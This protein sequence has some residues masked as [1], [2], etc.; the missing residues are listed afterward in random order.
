[1]T[2]TI[3]LLVLLGAAAVGR[4]APDDKPDLPRGPLDKFKALELAKGDDEERK[5]LKER[6]NV[7]VEVLKIELVLFQSGIRDWTEVAQATQRLYEAQIE[8]C[9]TPAERVAVREQQL[10]LARDLEHLASSKF[11]AGNGTKS[12][13]S[14]ARY[15]RIDAELQLLRA[16]KAAEAKAK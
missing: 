2:R 8:L 10:Q 4:A 15:F 16:K 9:E 3:A 14:R 11:E 12:D 13:V 6:Y 5:L 1:M 7:A